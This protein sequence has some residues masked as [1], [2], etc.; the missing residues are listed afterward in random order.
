MVCEVMATSGA[1][2]NELHAC[3]GT[4]S[5]AVPL[6]DHSTLVCCRVVSPFGLV[7]QGRY[8]VCQCFHVAEHS[9]LQ[10]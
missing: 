7:T 1:S 6:C 2:S 3:E 4:G 10:D 9:M 5:V 8:Q